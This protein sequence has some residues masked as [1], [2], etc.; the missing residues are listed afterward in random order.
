MRSATVNHFDSVGIE[1]GVFR[2][3]ILIV[4][5]ERILGEAGRVVYATLQSPRCLLISASR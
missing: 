1:D 4:P 2:R 5:G 3:L